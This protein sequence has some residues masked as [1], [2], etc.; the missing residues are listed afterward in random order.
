[1]DGGSVTFPEFGIYDLDGKLAVENHGVEPTLELD[2]LPHEEVAGRDPQLEKAV[3][4]LLQKIAAE[5]VRMPE[6]QGFPQ[7]RR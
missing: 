5:P 4:V 1:M 7:D 3:E 6:F 2:N